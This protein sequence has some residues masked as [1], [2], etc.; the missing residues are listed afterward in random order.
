[1][2]NTMTNLRLGPIA[3]LCIVLSG[4]ASTSDTN[5]VMVSKPAWVYPTAPPVDTSSDSLYRQST[6]TSFFEDNRAARV[7][8]LVSVLLVE[9]TMASKSSDTSI[10]KT[11]ETNISN[12][13]LGSKPVD[14]GD[15]F[16]LSVG[17]DSE[18]NFSGQSGSN[19]SNSLQG[20]IT[21]TVAAV[22]PRGKLVIEGEKW[23]KINQDNE[24]IRI[25]GIVRQVDIST[26]N[27]ILSTQVGNAEIDYGGTGPLSRANSMGWLS[28]F[29]NSPVWPF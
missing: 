18:Q 16:D 9:E 5:P 6:S 22:L 11:N 19:Q 8:D 7:G 2:A 1:M 3:L 29:F 15:G 25:R 28:R 24:Y 23:I 4:C 20:T 17:I 21:A 26:S 10:A 13:L 12:P 27:T 14:I